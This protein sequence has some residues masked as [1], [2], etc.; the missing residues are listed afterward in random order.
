MPREPIVFFTDRDLGPR[1]PQILSAA[2]LD[3]RRHQD[4]FAPDCADE[5]WLRAVTRNGWVAVSHDTR[6]RYKPNELAAV[7]ASGTRLLVVI[8]KAPYPELA[9]HFVATAPKI[10]ARWS[11]VIK[12]ANIKVN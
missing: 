9:K 11:K 1:F 3:V 8:G 10:I 4:L 6:I 5:V 12:T 2:G 7:R